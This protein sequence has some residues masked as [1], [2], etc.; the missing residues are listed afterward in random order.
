[1]KQQNIIES[2]NSAAEGFMYV[3]KTQKNMKFH[4]LAAVII[5]LAA[6]YLNIPPDQIL[7]LCCAISLVLIIEMVNTA[8]EY[9][10]DMFTQTFHPLARIIKDVMAGSVL[11]SAINAFVV[12]YLIFQRR[13][14]LYVGIGLMWIKQ[15]PWH[16]TFISIPTSSGIT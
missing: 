7:I 12:G 13:I 16:L 4:F 6:I 10:I 8:V 3:I 15:S 2:F 9:T 5:L 1:M 14:D 11:I